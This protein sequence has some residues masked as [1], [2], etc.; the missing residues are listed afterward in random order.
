[1]TTT[2]YPYTFNSLSTIGNDTATLDQRNIQNIAIG[3]Y[4][5]E[6][7][8][9]ACP[10]DKAKDFALKQ[11][12][13]FYKGGGEGG[14][15]GC[16]MD[17]NNELK[18]THLTKPACKIRLETRPYLG[19]PYLGRGPYHIDHESELLLGDNALNKK[20]VNLTMEQ[21]F[22]Q[23]HNYPLIDSLKSSITN[24]AYLIEEHAMDGWTRG[25]MSAREYARTESK[26]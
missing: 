14:I 6:N 2:N 12:N 8:Y 16:E 3:N 21:N 13:F 22:S 18:F 15:K 10:M 26:N 23:H 24:P 7:Y 20:S 4:E 11:P 1:M 19:M 5:L 25:G 17:A 9:P